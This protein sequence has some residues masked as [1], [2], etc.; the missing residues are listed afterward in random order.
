MIIDIRDTNEWRKNGIKG[1]TCIPEPH[2]KDNIDF[3]NTFESVIFV[4]STGLK[5]RIAAVKYMDLIEGNVT[6]KKI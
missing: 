5:A 4:C 1:S 6:F 2:L 3:L